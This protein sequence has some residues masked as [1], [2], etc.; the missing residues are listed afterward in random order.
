MRNKR[1]FAYLPRQLGFLCAFMAAVMFSMPAMAQ[2]H[3]VGVG[4]S[5][6]NATKVGDL[7][8]CTLSVTNRDEW[9]DSLSVNEFWDLISAPV[10][11]RNPAVGNLPIVAVDAGV[12]CVPA[13]VSPA[14]PIGLIFP[15]VIPGLAAIPNGSNLSIMV[16]SEYT[17]PDGSTDPLLD[18]GNVIVQ[19]GC[20]LQPVGC[21]PLPQQQ[22]FGAAVS[23][24]AP[25]LDVTKTGPAQAKVGDEITYTIGFTDTTT[26]TGFPGF[27]NCTGND[28]LLGGDLGEFTAG[29]TRDFPYTVQVGD[30][31]PLLN[32]ATITCGVV[33][34]D[35][36]VENSDG[37]SV[38]LI[39]PSIDVT[40]SG[41]ESAKVGDEITY[42]I[43]FTDTSVGGA[44]GTCT[45]NDPMLGGD[46]GVFTAGVTRDFPY[47]VQVG[48][49]DPL[50]N[51]ATITCDVVG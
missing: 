7:A 1:N 33:G 35:N 26:G 3:A 13:A 32:T 43:G 19:D 28:P 14:A 42:T 40:K 24:F 46:L 17:V 15:C 25:S 51:T 22:Q 18:Q 29:V 41:P 34:F 6:P 39:A 9:G 10:P 27:E 20:N 11:F 5:C 47:T 30:P 49:P 23:L 31:D 38:D 21:N 16:E 48:D 4:K 37:H 44:L 36:I 50:H 8:V 45:G 12:T 2:N